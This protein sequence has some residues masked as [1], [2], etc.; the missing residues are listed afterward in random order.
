[1]YDG[2]LCP[3]SQKFRR[4]TDN[5]REDRGSRK[6][7]VHRN[8][9]KTVRSGWE[10][11][12]LG[13]SFSFGFFIIVPTGPLLGRFATCISKRAS[14]RATVLRSDLREHHSSLS[15]AYRDY[16]QAIKGPFTNAE[17]LRF[18]LKGAA[19]SLLYF[20]YSIMFRRGQRPLSQGL[21]FNQANYAVSLL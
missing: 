13:I 4:A 12:S 2:A 9:R 20:Y 1:M 6:T 16:A 7:V 3:V 17:L 19:R 10:R 11:S 14:G 15:G 5:F 21:Y 8:E 18:L